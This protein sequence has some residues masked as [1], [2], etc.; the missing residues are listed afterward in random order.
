MLEVFIFESHSNHCNLR[1][2]SFANIN[3]GEGI[4]DG[5]SWAIFCMLELATPP[6]FGVPDKVLHHFLRNSYFVKT[7]QQKYWTDK[8]YIRSFKFECC[9][10][11]C[12]T[13][14]TKAEC[15]GYVKLDCDLLTH[16]VTLYVLTHFRIQEISRLFLV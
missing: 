5:H 3:T 13:R 9:A 2:Y 6:R 4:I 7:I 12:L 16:R 11:C 1:T 15:K 8:Q 10:E 14:K